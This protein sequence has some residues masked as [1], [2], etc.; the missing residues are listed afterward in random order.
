M[1]LK[2]WLSPG[3]VWNTLT[4]LRKLALDR[5]YKAERTGGGGLIEVELTTA[6]FLKLPS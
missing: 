6:E 2:Y 1:A 5:R 3:G 4:H